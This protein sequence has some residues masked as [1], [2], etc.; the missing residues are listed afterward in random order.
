MAKKGV[1]FI[2][3]HTYRGLVDKVSGV[4]RGYKVR[5]KDYDEGTSGHVN[6]EYR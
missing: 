3:V 5:I 4:P 1:K 2:T 6:V